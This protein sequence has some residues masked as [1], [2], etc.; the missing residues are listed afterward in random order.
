[1]EKAK[2]SHSR[3]PRKT[4]HDF[5]YLLNTYWVL[6]IVLDAKKKVVPTVYGALVTQLS[7]T[8]CNPMGWRLPSYSVPGVLQARILEGVAISSSGALPNPGIKP[9]SPALQADSLPT[10]L[11]G[12]P[13]SL[14]VY[15]ARWKRGFAVFSQSYIGH[16]SFTLASIICYKITSEMIHGDL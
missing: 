2:K 9:C 4:T 15:N 6:L 16:L 1:M 11:P 7:L 14:G 8:L 12:R 13:S 10:K 5:N 3:N